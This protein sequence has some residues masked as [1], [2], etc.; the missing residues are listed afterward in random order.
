MLNCNCKMQNVCYHRPAPELPVYA[1]E[2]EKYVRERERERFITAH[3]LT[4][5][6]SKS[7]FNIIFLSS[8]GLS[9][10]LVP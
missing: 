9:S 5:N 4:P 3:T 6:V 7:H 8:L 10:R 2:A 1:Q